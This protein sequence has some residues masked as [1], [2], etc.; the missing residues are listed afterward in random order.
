[1]AVSSPQY[2][3][4]TYFLSHFFV[5]GLHDF[6]DVIGCFLGISRNKASTVFYDTAN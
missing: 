1:M 6:G 3:E 4:N 5:G 2:S